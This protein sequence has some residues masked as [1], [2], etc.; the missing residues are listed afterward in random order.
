VDQNLLFNKDTRIFA[1]DDSPFSRKDK[2]ASIIGVIMRKDMYI[3]SLIKKKIRVDG[4]DV[5]DV[6]LEIL[7]E[8]GSG[9]K[10]VMTQGT[11]FAGFNI[12]DVR[13]IFERTKI[14][15]VNVVDHMPNM[16]SIKAAL[17]KYFD[18][19]EER[20]S[21]L[22]G[23]FIQFDSLFIQSTGLQPKV[24]HKFLMQMTVNGI[25]PE[26]LRIADLIAGVC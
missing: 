1:F 11:T 8:K 24:A 17:R 13:R 15:I 7:K 25:L 3:E 21:I 5:T 14:P 19:W 18:D 6:V 23:N 16:S 20:Y 10:L 4:S 2:F 22:V 26:P 9:I 12:L